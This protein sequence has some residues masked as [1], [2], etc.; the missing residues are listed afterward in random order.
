VYAHVCVRQERATRF[1]YAKLPLNEFVLF[2]IS[3]SE[4]TPYP[5]A[6]VFFYMCMLDKK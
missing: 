1:V 4:S 5:M 2:Y 6:N 3:E